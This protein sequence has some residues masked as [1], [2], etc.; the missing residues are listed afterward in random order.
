MS[1]RLALLSLLLLAC[2]GDDDGGSTGP[3]PSVSLHAREVVRDLAS[4]VFLTAPAG[5]ARLFVVEQEGRVRIVKDG[6]L[7]PTPFLDITAKVGSGGERGLLSIAFHPSY[8]QNGFFYVNYTNV[9]GDTRVE[10]YHVSANPDLADASSGSPVLAVDQPFDNH[11]GGLVAFGPDGMLYVGMGDGGDAGD[12]QGNAQ[13]LN[14]LLGKLL[15]IDVDGGTPYAVPVDNPYVGRTDA[16][17]EIW[18]SGLRNPW[19]FAWDAAANRVYVADVG[20]GAREEVTV[21]AADAPALNY[22]WPVLEGSACFGAAACDATGLLRP[23][24]EYDH[25]AGCS[26][27]GGYVY[28]GSITALHGHYFYSDFCGGWLRSA[29]VA[30]DGTVSAPTEWPVGPLGN[31]TSFGEDGAGELYVISASGIVYVIEAAT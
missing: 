16:L 11:N 8:A 4:P 28:R 21:V 23:T 12:P 18:A 3:P 19:R 5:D 29:R 22:G 26:I 27:T 2:G 30:A 7:L 6:Q 13:R 17:P 20:Q 31:V 15:R 24:F 9:D 1:S 10:R 25:D 14:T